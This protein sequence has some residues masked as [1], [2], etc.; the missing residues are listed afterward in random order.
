MT[1]T[2]WILEEVSIERSRQDAKWGPQNHNIFKW[3]SI[4]GEEVGEANNAA[5]ERDWENFRVECIQIA[6]VAAAMAEA[7]DDERCTHD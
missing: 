1:K 7:L 3:L 5:L 6:A 4:L 2:D